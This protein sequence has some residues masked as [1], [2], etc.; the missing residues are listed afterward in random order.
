MT[1]VLCELGRWMAEG[2]PVALATLVRVDGSAP[3]RAGAR[4]LVTASGRIAGSV[5]GG[6][7]ESD[8]VARALRVLESGVPDLVSY[9][10][11]DP[12]GLEIGLLCGGRIEVL[13]ERVDGDPSWRALATAL[14]DGC[15]LT[16]C[17]ALRPDHLRG[18]KL[19]V[20]GDGETCGAIDAG[21]DARAAEFARARVG[22][23]GAEIAEITSPGGPVA[24]FVE[25]IAPAP[26]LFLVG[27][28][29]TAV[30]LAR[31]AKTVGYRV[32][33][34]D[35]RSAF[36]GPE[37]FPDADAC[38][39]EW[40]ESAFERARLDA[41]DS[42]VTLTHDPKIDLPALECGLRA[43]VRYLGALGSRT[44]HARRC[45]GLR[46]RGFGDAALAAI[47]AP[48]G[49]DLGARGPAE[50]ALAVLAEMIAVRNRADAR[51]L[52]Q[53][54]GRIHAGRRVAGRP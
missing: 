16:L 39:P 11:A 36:L 50:I 47:R 10:S 19:L 3:Q 54:S 35:P 30:A 23:E 51:P 14:A 17:V 5:S 38:M 28:T 52:A 8:V 2:E 13:I 31:L 6:C 12:E 44:T 22:H 21:I 46:E 29:H 42:L 27:A 20:L 40:P 18:R 32:Y 25:A 24:L 53:G 43:G 41:R 48:V 7:V 37:R 15:P 33:V 1:D 45:A 4:M 49:L 34:V 9:A 26:R